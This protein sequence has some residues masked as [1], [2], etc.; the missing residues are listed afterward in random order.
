MKNTGKQNWKQN[1]NANAVTGYTVENFLYKVKPR[2]TTKKI[3]RFLN[4]LIKSAEGAGGCQ[5]GLQAAKWRSDSSVL[6]SFA[7]SWV[8][9][10]APS[11]SIP[12]RTKNR[13]VRSNATTIQNLKNCN[14]GEIVSPIKHRYTKSSELLRTQAKQIVNVKVLFYANINKRIF[15]C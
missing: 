1:F 9:S 15:E 4:S 6:S 8:S 11:S 14:A 10:R 2:S 5:S 12:K 3:T 7:G 13:C